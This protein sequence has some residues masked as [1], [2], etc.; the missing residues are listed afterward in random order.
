MEKVTIGV[1]LLF[2]AALGLCL[3]VVN[4]GLGKGQREREAAAEEFVGAI[5][6]EFKKLEESPKSYVMAMVDYPGIMIIRSAKGVSDELLAEAFLAKFGDDK[7]QLTERLQAV[8]GLTAE[9]VG[10]I[11]GRYEQKKAVTKEFVQ[12]L[13]EEMNQQ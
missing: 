5:K 6:E 1:G 2:V 3:Y 8:R 10:Q 4:R 11:R 9:E 12:S 13:K 7:Q